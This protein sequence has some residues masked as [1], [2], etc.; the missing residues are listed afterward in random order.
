MDCPFLG[1]EIY[2]DCRGDV[3][4]RETRGRH[5]LLAHGSFPK[6]FT[7]T[8]SVPLSVTS[9]GLPLGG[10]AAGARGSATVVMHQRSGVSATGRRSSG[11]SGP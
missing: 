10:G 2:D 3:A 5:R 9:A 8:F 6:E 1:G 11:G 4:I 7:D